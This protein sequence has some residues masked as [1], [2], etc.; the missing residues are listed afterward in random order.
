LSFIITHG[1]LPHEPSI[2][3]TGSL[4]SLP[5]VSEVRTKPVGIEGSSKGLEQLLKEEREVVRQCIR[6]GITDVALQ[7]GRNVLSRSHLC[8]IGIY[9]ELGH[10]VPVCPRGSAPIHIQLAHAPAALGVRNRACQWCVVLRLAVPNGVD[11]GYMPGS[12]IRGLANKL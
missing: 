1:L 2:N 10:D 11:P 4:L 9:E 8:L 6:Q 12:I 5:Q 3:T 7:P